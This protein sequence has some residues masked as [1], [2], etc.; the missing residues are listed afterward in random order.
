MKLSA[1]RHLLLAIT[2]LALAS[3]FTGCETVEN[4]LYEPVPYDEVADQLD[5]TM[6]EAEALGMVQPK[7]EL[8]PIINT[9]TGFIPAPGVSS[10]A[11]LTLNGALAMG[12]VW[13]GKKKRTAEKVSASLVQ[14]IDVFRDILDQTPQ[15]AKIDAS[16]TKTLKD[17]Q[18]A[19]R[20]EREIHKLLQRYATPTKEPIR[21]ED[22]A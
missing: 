6:E 19:L 4:A 15:G 7:P 8:E 16:L 14:G 5:I 11:S 22:A 18:H 2:M 13:L 3:M 9:L 12:A 20:V 10:L 1:I 17:Q 21:L